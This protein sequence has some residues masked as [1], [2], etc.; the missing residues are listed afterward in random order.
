MHRGEHQANGDGTLN[1]SA[2][3][4]ELLRQILRVEALEDES[5][6]VGAVKEALR[7]QYSRGFHEGVAEGMKGTAVSDA[8]PREPGRR[9]SSSEYQGAP[10]SQERRKKRRLRRFRQRVRNALVTTVMLVLAG[11]ALL[12]INAARPELSATNPRARHRIDFGS[13]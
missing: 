6:L 4:H 9:L 12:A 3:S 13:P 1:L 7:L 11:A 2:E 10:S 5:A 8:P